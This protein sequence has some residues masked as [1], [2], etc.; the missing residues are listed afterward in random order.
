MSGERTVAVIQARMTS[1]RLPGKVLLP[2]AGRPML[3]RVVER[4]L[5]APGIDVVCVAVPEGPAHQPLVD[6]AETMPGVV[7]VRGPEH[8]VLHRTVLAAQET[9]ATTVVRVTSDC[10]FLDPGVTGAVVAAQLS[11]GVPYARTAFSTGFPLGFDTEAVAVESLLSADIEA[12]DPYEREHVTPFIWRRPAR[13]PNLYL[14]RQPDLRS[15]RLV[16]DSPEDYGLACEVYD[17][18]G[19]DFDLTAL[20][21]VFAA[22]PELLQ[23]N[24]NVEQTPYVGLPAAGETVTDRPNR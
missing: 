3:T 7:A 5:R 16:V 4:A 10:P 23:I 24:A 2:L 15:W 17:L 22:R 18:L 13:F 14:D 12:T 11:A 1:T 9:G 8:D 19:A 6:L 21:E 20:A